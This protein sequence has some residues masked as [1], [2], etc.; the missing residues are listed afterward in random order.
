MFRKLVV[1]AV[2]IAGGVTANAGP[3]LL[4]EGF[5]DI[6]TLGGWL[7]GNFS[8]PAGSG[9]WFQ[10]NSA[11]FGSDEGAA[12][13]YIAANYTAAADTGG[14]VDLWLVTPL[15][16]ASMGVVNLTFSTRTAGNLPGDSIEILVN[17]TG[18][19]STGDFVSLGTIGPDDFP[20]DWSSFLFAYDGVSA[21]IRFAFRY[22]VAD[23]AVGG[24]YIG[25][26]TVRASAPEPGTLA[27]LAM[28]LLLTPLVLRRRRARI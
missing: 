1:S 19:L 25:I 26:D 10:G 17:N 3:V 27:L 4:E 21:N 28:G 16:D 5:D 20:T 8:S 14:H 12:D 18:S 23:T 15:I 13:S 22:L 6:N 24:D 2:L 9:F 11:I 7:A